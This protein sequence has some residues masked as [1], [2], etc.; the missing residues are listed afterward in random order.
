MF[1]FSLWIAFAWTVLYIAFSAI[2]LVF[3]TKHSFDVEQSG[4]V[5]SGKVVVIRD[6]R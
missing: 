4:A 3:T 5:F 1:F 2:P 6:L